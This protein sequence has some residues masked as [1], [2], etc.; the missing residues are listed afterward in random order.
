MKIA[1][2]GY[3]TVGSGVAEVLE[4][5]RELIARRA[6]QE[7]EIKYVLDLRDF[8]GDKIQ[9][10]IVHDY[11]IIAEDP[12][13]EAVV[14]VMGGIEPAHTFVK[15]ALLAGRHAVTSNKALVARHGAELLEIAR[16]KKVNF[17]FEASVGGGIPILRALGSSLT[18]D[19][20]EEVSGILNGTTNYMM[21]KMFYEG[22][23]YDTVLKEAQANGFAEADPTADVEGQDACRKIAILASIIS[24]KNVEFEKIY[25]EGITR[26]TKEDMAYARKMGMT[27]KLLAQCRRDG[28][29]LAAFVSPFLLK[30]SHPLYSVN[31]V[32]NAVFV[33]GNMLGDAMF[34]GSGAGKLPTASAVV[35]DIIAAAKNPDK[36]IMNFWSREELKLESR[37]E[38]RRR[39]FVRA[40]GEPRNLEGKI[41][42][43]FGNCRFVTVEGLDGEFGFVTP[44]MSEGDFAEKAG[45]C[46]WI[47]HMIRVEE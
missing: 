11:Q 36:D 6:G 39:F 17:L 35:A 18:A 19:E 2:L 32:F 24:G 31:G 15:Q 40:E 30:S 5:N 26:V 9:E 16:E 7:I 42:A 12:E 46:P 45:N 21:T 28:E 27:V 10:K 22:A 44:V 47:L 41:Q 20:I 1:V 4:T 34:Y 29:K 23:D 33:K 13:I 14:E 37:E 3:G 38:I 43:E 8:P 25:T